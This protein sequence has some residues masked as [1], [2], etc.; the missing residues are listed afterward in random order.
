[1]AVCFTAAG[2]AACHLIRLIL[3]LFFSFVEEAASSIRRPIQRSNYLANWHGESCVED[4]LQYST[5]SG[6]LFGVSERAIGKPVG[7]PQIQRRGRTTQAGLSQGLGDSGPGS[8]FTRNDFNDGED[9]EFWSFALAA[10]GVQ[11]VGT[12]MIEAWDG[13]GTGM[14][15]D[16]YLPFSRAT[17]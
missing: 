6:I 3:V 2:L 11:P 1:M 7:R 15:K 9:L 5:A 12:C 4:H 14:S 17:F 16:P 8:C 10:R 13:A